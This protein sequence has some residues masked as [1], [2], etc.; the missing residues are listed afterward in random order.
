MFP[1]LLAP[2]NALG[3]AV[4]LTFTELVH[5]LKVKNL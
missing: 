1:K 2:W 4:E 5:T 3:E